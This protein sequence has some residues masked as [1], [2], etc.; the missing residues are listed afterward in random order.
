MSNH[1]PPPWL[2]RLRAR[3]PTTPTSQPDPHKILQSVSAV[4]TVVLTALAVFGYIYTVIP[5]YQKSLLDE[6]IAKKTIELNRV[7]SQLAATEQRLREITP[8]LTKLESQ[9]NS[10]KTDLTKAQD[11]A[12][13]LYSELRLQIVSWLAG[14]LINECSYPWEPKYS[15]VVISTQRDR[16]QSPEASK[17]VNVFAECIKKVNS[18]PEVKNELSKLSKTDLILGN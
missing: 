10:A 8:A 16:V 11:R 2:A 4:A 15:F 18:S 13:S 6:E 12:R 14:R 5:V 7:N 17:G 9:L 3:K 1:K